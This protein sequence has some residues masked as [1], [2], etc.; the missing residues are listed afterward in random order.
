MSADPER[1]GRVA[2]ALL[3]PALEPIVDMVIT[4]DDG[5]YDVRAVDG[6]VRFTRD[7]H[8]DDGGGGGGPRYV[9]TLVEG[10]DPRG[11]GC[12]SHA[13]RTAT[14]VAAGTGRATSR[15]WWRGATRWATP[16]PTGS[17]PWPTS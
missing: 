11:G 12:V 3:D 7:A 8:R 17:R 2:D 5:G 16:P 1:V 10:G 13:T 6:R 9:E 14:T 15:P 4:T